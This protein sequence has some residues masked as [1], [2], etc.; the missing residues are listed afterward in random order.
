MSRKGRKSQT[1]IEQERRSRKEAWRKHDLD[2]LVFIV[3][4]ML[5]VFLFAWITLGLFPAP[6]S[7]VMLFGLAGSFILGFGLVC[8]VFAFKKEGKLVWTKL[9]LIIY[10][11]GGAITLLSC[12]VMYVPPIYGLFNEDKMTQYV[13]SVLFVLMLPTFYSTFRYGVDSWL[14]RQHVSKTRIKAMKKG[15]RNYWW[16]EEIHRNYNMG[17]WYYL[18]VFVTGAYPVLLAVVLLFGWIPVVRRI[19]NVLYVSMAVCSS[20][21]ILFGVAQDNLKE[22][23]RAFLWVRV[24]KDCRGRTILGTGLMEIPSACFPLL[25]AWGY[26]AASKLF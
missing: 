19:S 6:N 25:M 7:I 13:L 21:M 2:A 18:N 24:G 10:A 22:E 15:R 5:P 8:Q 26:V 3:A 1:E 16:Y 23:G 4:L 20:L 11:I 9:V 17:I 14:R 12:V